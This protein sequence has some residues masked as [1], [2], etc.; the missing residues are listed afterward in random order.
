MGAGGTNVREDGCMQ[1]F[2]GETGRKE[3][4][5]NTQA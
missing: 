5:W 1:H 2:G 3:K 4:T